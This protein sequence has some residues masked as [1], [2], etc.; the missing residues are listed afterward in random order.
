MTMPDERYR[1][2]VQ[3]KK[4]LEDLC[5]RQTTPRVSRIVRERAMGALRHFPSTYELEKIAETSPVYLDK[6]P[7][8]SK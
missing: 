5:N 3:G 1:A 4:L 2:L 6:I 7:Y 8:G